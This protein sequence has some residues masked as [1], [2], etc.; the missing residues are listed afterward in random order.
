MPGAV[1]EDAEED[2]RRLNV[3]HCQDISGKLSSESKSVILGFM[4]VFE[5]HLQ[6]EFGMDYY[7]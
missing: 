7:G 1:K 4:N 3:S 6:Q 2:T 5:H